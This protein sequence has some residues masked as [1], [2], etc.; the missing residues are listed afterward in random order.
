MFADLVEVS[1]ALCN[2]TTVYCAQKSQV[3]SCGIPP[4]AK[5]AKDGA[6]VVVL[7]PRKPQVPPLRYAPVGMT[8]QVGGWKFGTQTEV[9]SRPERSAVE[10]PAVSYKGLR[11]R[12][13][14]PSSQLYYIPLEPDPVSG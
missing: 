10:R 4:F 8:L 13:S 5:N 12:C 11:E 3:E 7:H 2:T 6:P 9:S 1:E 14:A